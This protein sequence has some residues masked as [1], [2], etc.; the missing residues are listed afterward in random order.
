MHSMV[1]I[2]ASYAKSQP[3]KLFIADSKGNEYTYA[4]A[5]EKVCQ[6][7]HFLSV[8]EELVIGDR[9]MVECNQDVYF[10][11]ADLAC[12]LIGVV[13]VPIEGDASE[14]R[15][16]SIARET[17]AKIWISKEKGLSTVQGLSYER[18][19]A[20]EEKYLVQSFPVGDQVAEILYTTG[21][22]GTSKGIMITNDS[23]V[24]LAEN[25]KYGVCMRPGNTEMIPVPISH[26]HGVR[27]CYANLL[28][29]GTIV[30]V[31]G[32]LQIKK[33]FAMIEQYHVTALDVS[34]SAAQFLIKVSKGK[35]W[36]I[37]RSFD[38]IQIGTAALP[39]QLKEQLVAE[40]KGV[41]L[42]NFYGSTESGRSCVLDFS[43]DTGR[44]NCI[45]KATRNAEII[46][47]DD[48][49]NVFEATLENPG[50]LASRGT[51]NMLGYWKNFELTQQIMSDG[52]VFTN[53]LGYADADGYIYVLG[54][55]DDVINYNGI[56]IAPEEIEEIAI[57]YCGVKDAACV[58]M[59]DTVAG[60]VPKLYIV[61][62]NENTF[63]MRAFMDYLTRNLDGNKMPK[64]VEQ[65]DEIPR[66]YNGKIKRKELVSR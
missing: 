29:G 15:K 27:C 45:G 46:F 31:D 5:W 24:A 44:Q 19:F 59:S 14:D 23:N 36:E 57:K 64:F 17:E 56:K 61:I 32:L 52:F 4:Q 11:L 22:T 25:I 13:F 2:L 21:T 39:E 30:L 16:E 18:L 3:E 20:W 37:G 42:Y 12:E 40:L 26:S 50:L 53:D 43:I 62:E 66:T 35:F 10:L 8:K 6:V 49:R 63:Q 9:A 34:P 65:I 41:R 28:N 55:K 47:T 51:M 38:Y 58:P 54:R 60:Q 1:E 7:A 48:D 33:V